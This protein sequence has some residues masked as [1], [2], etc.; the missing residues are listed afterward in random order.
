MR[1]SRGKLEQLF[2]SKNRKLRHKAAAQR[3]APRRESHHMEALSRCCKE[4]F[5]NLFSFN[6]RPFLLQGTNLGKLATVTGCCC[7]N[8]ELFTEDSWPASAGLVVT[9]ALII[10]KSLI[11]ITGCESPVRCK[12]TYK[13]GS[14]SRRLTLSTPLR[15][16]SH[17]QVM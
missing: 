11:L 6:L 16:P 17:H 7:S 15:F 14:L 8:W 10:W 4:H 13:L 2:A 3:P 1:C 5:R 9:S 12:H